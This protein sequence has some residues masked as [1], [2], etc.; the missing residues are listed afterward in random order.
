MTI[1]DYLNDILFTKGDKSFKNI[2]DEA[3]F[4]PYLVNR[5]ISMYSPEVAYLIN[6]TTNK[7]YST[8]TEKHD[9]FKLL[10]S[11]IPKMSRK[12]INYIKK[13]KKDKEN[14]Q[15]CVDLLAKNLEIS[16]KEIYIYINGYREDKKSRDDQ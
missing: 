4:Q 15:E 16:K 3:D 1:F 8:F 2:E 6:E 5:W 11:V 14:I 13:P 12:R 9:I 7:Y 10:R